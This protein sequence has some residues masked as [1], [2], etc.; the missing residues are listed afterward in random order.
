[1]SENTPW[2]GGITAISN[3]GFGGTNVHCLL[4]GQVDRQPALAISAAHAVDEV[5][6][7]CDVEADSKAEVYDCIYFVLI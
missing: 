6:E 4:E 2:E 1:M 3:F 5:A 7:T